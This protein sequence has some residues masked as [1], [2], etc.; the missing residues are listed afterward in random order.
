MMQ[1]WHQRVWNNSNLTVETTFR[2][3][4]AYVLSTLLYSSESLSAYARHEKKLNR[5]HLRC[6][7]R[8]LHITWREKVTKS[9]VLERAGTNT[10]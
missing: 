6:L 5:F 9:E 8:I 4:P 10:M 2:V 7:R 1:R 3:Y